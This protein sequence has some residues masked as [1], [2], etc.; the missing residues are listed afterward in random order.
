MDI[1]P[2]TIGYAIHRLLAARGIQ[3]GSSLALRTLAED[4]P[5][6]LLRKTDLGV[7]IEALR[8]SG[9]LA[10]EHAQEG[11]VVRL[12][13]EQ[14]GMIRTLQD[15]EAVATLGRLR[16]ARRPPKPHL[17]ALLGAKAQ[18]RRRGE[19]GAEKRARS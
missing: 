15:R 16:E 12:L 1:T 6:T 18:G 13:N 5:E 19:A 17:V 9:H 7:G 10:L 14:F 4:W 3:Q 8:K 11:P 2:K